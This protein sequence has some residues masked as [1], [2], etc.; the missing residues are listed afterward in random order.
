[1]P[2]EPFPADM[3]SAALH[4][5]CDDGAAE[6]LTH[7]RSDPAVGDYLV[8][9]MRFEG[10]LRS[11]LRRAAPATRTSRRAA[12]RPATRRRRATRQHAR[13]RGGRRFV[14]ALL[15]V[16]AVIA[17]AVTVSMSSMSQRD[18]HA[19]VPRLDGQLVQV[20]TWFTT[21]SDGATLTWNDG[22][23]ARMAANSRMLIRGDNGVIALDRGTIT[24]TVTPHLATR[25]FVVTTDAGGITVVGTIFTVDHSHDRTRLDVSRGQVRLHTN[26]GVSAVVPAGGSGAIDAL[27]SLLDHPPEG[28]VAWRPKS[29]DVVSGSRNTGNTLFGDAMWTAT[30]P[31]TVGKEAVFGVQWKGDL[32][33]W[34]DRAEL[35]FDYAVDGSVPWLGM[36]LQ[37][38]TQSGPNFFHSVPL[39]PAWQWRSLRIPL[40]QIR[41]NDDS[42]ARP[43]STQPMHWLFF[44]AGFAADGM[45]HVANVRVVQ[46]V[47]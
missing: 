23:Q 19:D 3:N 17:V 37:N 41:A 25:P 28:P 11:E 10:L 46:P 20:D 7:I 6:L 35:C 42:S 40:A 47:K 8:R 44:Q 34:D 39:P 16:A 26:A 21:A 9:T 33:T 12:A 2:S 32:F 4:A 45:L 18:L 15:A 29:S 30:A 36:W 27:G 38:P 24:A 14:P 13:A 5:W 1:M 43:V 22:S 31:P